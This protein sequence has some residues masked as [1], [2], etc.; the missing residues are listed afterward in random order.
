V[1]Q[2]IADLG[3]SADAFLCDV[4]RGTVTDV[5]LHA[6]LHL[7]RLREFVRATGVDLDQVPAW[8]RHATSWRAVAR[9]AA[10]GD[11]HP[12]PGRERLNAR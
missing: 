1:K 9:I 7:R 3:E 4:H 8:S 2:A 12:A 10:A 5:R 6:E 11:R